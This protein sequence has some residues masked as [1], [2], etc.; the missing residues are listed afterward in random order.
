MGGEW[1][2][3]SNTEEQGARCASVLFNWRPPD[4]LL[5]PYASHHPLM[6]CH[7]MHQFQ[8]QTCRAGGEGRA[9]RRRSVVSRARAAAP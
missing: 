4:L 9:S 8:A 5:F 1:K 7:L 3:G 6:S 2:Q